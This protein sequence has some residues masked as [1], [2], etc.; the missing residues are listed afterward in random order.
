MHDA[1]EPREATVDLFDEVPAPFL[2][3]DVTHHRDAPVTR[4]IYLGPDRFNLNQPV[5]QRQQP[6]FADDGLRDFIPE[7]ATHP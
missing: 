7:A 6:A 4:W 1:V 3:G 2:I 5:A